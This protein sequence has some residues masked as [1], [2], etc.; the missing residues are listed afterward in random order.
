MK[1]STQPAGGSSGRFT[2]VELEKIATKAIAQFGGDSSGRCV[3]V[4][5]K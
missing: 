2:L 1:A 4:E 5:S 3:F